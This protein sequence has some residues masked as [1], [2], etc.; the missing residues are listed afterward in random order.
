M[1]QLMGISIGINIW[2]IVA[3]AGAFVFGL[4]IGQASGKRKAYVKFLEQQ[5][6]MEATR[7]WAQNLG[8]MVEAYD[9]KE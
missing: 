6:Q 3:V 2:I 5:R 7:L 8:K 9:V 4:L 1:N